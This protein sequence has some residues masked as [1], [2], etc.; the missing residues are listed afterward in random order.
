MEQRIRLILAESRAGPPSKGIIDINVI[1]VLFTGIN[2]NSW[3]FDTGSVA[4][5]CNTMQ[6]LRKMRKL[7]KGEMTMRVGNGVLLDAKAVGVVTLRP[8]GFTLE[9]NKCYFV[10]EL[11]KNIIYGSCL[12]RD[13]YSFKSEK[14]WF[15]YLYE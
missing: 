3:V 1:D 6:G 11:C 8:S 15:F 10:P 7:A 9:L 12:L 13:G 2:S 14:K 4:H 5:I